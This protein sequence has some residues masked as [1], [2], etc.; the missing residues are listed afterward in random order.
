MKEKTLD[1]IA[2]I[3]VKDWNSPYFGAIPYLNAMCTLESVSDYYGVESG[4]SIVRY[5]LAN[6]GSWRGEVAREV[7][8]ELKRRVK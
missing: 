5:F 2:G 1:Q 6:A 8:K 7:K 4:K 3:I